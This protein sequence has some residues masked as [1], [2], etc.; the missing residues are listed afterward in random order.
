[1]ICFVC[2]CGEQKLEISSATLSRDP[3]KT[4][5]AN[6][7]FYYNEQTKVATFGGQGE[8]IEYYSED[9]TLGRT[10]GCR[11][12]VKIEAP[13]DL[14]DFSGATL[15]FNGRLYDN[16]Q[17]FE[18]DTKNIYIYPI[19]SQDNTKNVVEII[20]NANAKPQTYII[21]IA[22]GTNF[23]SPTKTVNTLVRQSDRN[24]IKDGIFGVCV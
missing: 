2:A 5:G 16:T 18:S 3:A 8:V 21:E 22:Q 11:V 23:S 7:S 12:G 10:G 4:G 13:K 6:L 14:K 15:S 1:M 24:F 19:V 17:M 9:E 20:W